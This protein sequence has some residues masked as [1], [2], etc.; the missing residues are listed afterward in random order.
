MVCELSL[1]KAAAE[2]LSSQGAHCGRDAA[3]AEPTGEAGGPAMRSSHA[4]WE[5]QERN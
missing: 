1:S 3:R 5:S 4:V 2:A